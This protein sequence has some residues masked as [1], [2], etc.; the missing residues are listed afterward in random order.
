MALFVYPVAALMYLSATSHLAAEGEPHADLFENAHNLAPANEL[1]RGELPY[2][3][4]ITAHGLLQDGLVDSL[5]MRS[6]DVTAGRLLEVRGVISSFNSVAVY[7]LGA[8]VTGSPDLGLLAFFLGAVMGTSGGTLRVLPA[9]IALALLAAGVRRRNMRLIGLAGAATVIAALMSLDF[10]FYTF[11]ALIFALWRLGR[12]AAVRAAAIGIAAAGIPVM[13]AFAVYRILDDFLRVTFTE[14]LRLGPVYTLRPF[15]PT[16]SLKTRRFFPDV[17]ASLVDRDGFLFMFWIACLLALVV[18]VAAP[19]RDGIRTR[20]RG[21]VEALTVILAWTVVT[22]ISYAERNNLYFQYVVQVVLVV[23]AWLLMRGRG[24]ASR[25]AGTAV[26]AIAL[27]AFQPTHYLIVVSMLRRAN[28][29]MSP[30]LVLVN[31]P[32]RA[33]G[34]LYTRRDAETMRIASDFVS[35]TLAPDETFFDFTNRGALYFLLNRDVPIRQ[36]EVAF[37]Q[38]EEQQNEVIARLAAN[39]KVRLALVPA[40]GDRSVNLD[41]VPNEVRAPRVWAYLREHFRPAFEHDRV[42]FWERIE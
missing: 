1:L 24:S 13:I 20:R 16:T 14:I 9:L 27:I 32:P 31:N 34:A 26:I 3:D 36:M 15:A 18:I 6:G 25:L 22:A 12:A 30:D 7:A 11:A 42:V 2:R 33:A 41:G 40:A 19:R 23:T 5:V 38:T 21:I 8:A 37:Y 28:G 10:G 17:L 39:P 35:R 29:P 4:I